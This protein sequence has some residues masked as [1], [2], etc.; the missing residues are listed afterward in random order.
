M[1]KKLYNIQKSIIIQMK[2]TPET[3]KYVS[4]GYAYAWANDIYPYFDDEN[5]LHKGYEDEF[6]LSKEKISEI[7]EYLDKKWKNGKNHTFYEL[8]DHFHVLQGDLNITRHDLINILRYTYLNDRF[9]DKFWDKL[10]E[11]SDYPIEAESITSD[12][13]PIYIGFN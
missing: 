11:G 8:E 10:L 1:E 4:E 9:D 5:D 3:S 2:L 6:E 7:L 12:F 13:N